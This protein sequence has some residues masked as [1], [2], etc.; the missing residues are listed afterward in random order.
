MSYPFLDSM[1]PSEK[2]GF[3]VFLPATRIFFF[4]ITF[5]FLFLLLFLLLFL[6]D[7]LFLITRRRLQ[8]MIWLSRLSKWKLKD[9]ADILYPDP[10]P[11]SGKLF[12]SSTFLF[13]LSLD[14]ANRLLTTASFNDYYFRRL[15]LRELSPARKASFPT[16]TFI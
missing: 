5:L 9:F 11:S 13:S 10:P 14:S 15:L 2:I 3:L 12:F 1:F 16:C 7:F 8:C 4:F 6:D